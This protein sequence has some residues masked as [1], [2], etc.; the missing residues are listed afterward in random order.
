MGLGVA[1]TN[2]ECTPDIVKLLHVPEI[3]TIYYDYDYNL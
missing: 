2:N 1:Y 3:L